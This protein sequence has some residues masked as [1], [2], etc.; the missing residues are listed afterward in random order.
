MTTANI[1]KVLVQY[2]E[3]LRPFVPVRDVSQPKSYMRWMCCQAIS[4]LDVANSYSGHR[5]VR[6]EMIEQANRWLGFIQGVLW[7]TGEFTIDQMREHNYE[8][9]QPQMARV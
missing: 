7:T 5:E 2:D 8:P 4:M 1:R 9:K 3:Y 6:S